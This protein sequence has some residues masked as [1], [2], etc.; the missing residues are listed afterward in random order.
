MNGKN[1]ELKERKKDE[2]GTG[3]TRNDERKNEER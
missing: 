3:I 1:N 2:R